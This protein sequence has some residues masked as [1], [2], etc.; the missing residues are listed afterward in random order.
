MDSNELIRRLAKLKGRLLD[1]VEHLAA[2]LANLEAEGP[3]SSAGE[4]TASSPRLTFWDVSRQVPGNKE[5]NLEGVVRGLEERLAALENWRE[6]LAE[7]LYGQGVLPGPPAPPTPSS[8]E[9]QTGS[10]PI[11]AQTLQQLEDWQVA[12]D[13]DR[14]KTKRC[15]EELHQ[16]I[17]GAE[18]RLAASEE[19]RKTHQWTVW[20]T[21]LEGG[22]PSP[23]YSFLNG[24]CPSCGELMRVRV[25]TEATTE[26]MTSP[27]K[28]QGDSS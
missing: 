23:G 20:Q 26:P 27:R 22:P 17:I 18:R 6:N 9:E 12:V 4:E 7:T 5:L 25:D 3:M 16:M 10:S 21:S 19:F 2:M 1:D 15:L 28:M 11:A 13:R 24:R 8:G 14:D